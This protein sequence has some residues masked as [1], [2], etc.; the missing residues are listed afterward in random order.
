MR[1]TLILN[2]GNNNQSLEYYYLCNDMIITF[3]M[4]QYYTNNNMTL[5]NMY[6]YIFTILLR[7]V[8]FHNAPYRQSMVRASSLTC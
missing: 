7:L 8:S 3:L 4:K 1:K 6:I 5:T 2:E